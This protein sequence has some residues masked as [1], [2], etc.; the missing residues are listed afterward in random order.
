MTVEV[1]PYI[2]RLTNITEEEADNVFM[3]DG[4]SWGQEVIHL[5]NGGMATAAHSM[6]A[7]IGEETM[8]SRQLLMSH[9]RVSGECP[10]KD[11]HCAC[12]L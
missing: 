11:R 2:D 9:T 12:Q 5:P 10:Y 4:S 6:S 3:P 1:V 7:A 8:V